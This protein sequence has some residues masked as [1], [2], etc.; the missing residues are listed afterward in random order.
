M[1][2]VNEQAPIISLNSWFC[3]VS[4]WL[5]RLGPVGQCNIFFILHV[6]LITDADTDCALSLTFIAG[7]LRNRHYCIIPRRNYRDVKMQ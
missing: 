2:K 6:E 7:I 3:F 4:G 5:V 1:T